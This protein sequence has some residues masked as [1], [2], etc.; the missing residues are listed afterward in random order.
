MASGAEDEAGGWP[1]RDD[2]RSARA[3]GWTAERLERELHA[4]RFA[5]P[6]PPGRSGT[7]ADRGAAGVAGVGWLAA[8]MMAAA[9]VG[10]LV[11]L[12]WRV[13]GG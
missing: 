4:I 7:V 12:F 2:E 9:V 10:C 5:R 3:E 1:P 8:G 11:Y 6:R 13:L